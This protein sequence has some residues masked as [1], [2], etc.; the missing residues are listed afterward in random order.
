M[1]MGVLFWIIAF[2][3]Q[4][5][6]VWSIRSYLRLSLFAIFLC[7]VAG[8]RINRGR[9]GRLDLGLNICLALFCLL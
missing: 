8:I 7:F 1:E 6:G 2:R 4:L 3:V 5:H 9:C